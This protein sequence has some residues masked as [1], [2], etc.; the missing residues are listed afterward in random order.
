[1]ARISAEYSKCTGAKICVKRFA[2]VYLT[3]TPQGS[4]KEFT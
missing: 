4:G 1:M 3:V 2:N